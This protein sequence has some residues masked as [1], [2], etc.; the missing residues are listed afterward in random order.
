MCGSLLI[1]STSVFHWLLLE[2]KKLPFSTQNANII[3]LATI[4]YVLFELMTSNFFILEWNF[5]YFLLKIQLKSIND[6]NAFALVWHLRFTLLIIFCLFAR[7]SR[8]ARSA[9]ECVCV[10]CVRVDMV[11]VVYFH[12]VKE[13]VATPYYQIRL[14]KFHLLWVGG[15]YKV[16]YIFT[17]HLKKLYSAICRTFNLHISK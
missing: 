1:N 12:V 16:L 7:H 8:P 10:V 9:W 3:K 6:W 4:R 14:R 5:D 11:E 15:G 13:N 17:L 2:Y